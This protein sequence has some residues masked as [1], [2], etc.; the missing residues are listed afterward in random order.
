MWFNNSGCCFFQKTKEDVFKTKIMLLP[1]QLERNIKFGKNS[2]LCA[3]EGYLQNRRNIS[4]VMNEE[5]HDGY[6]AMKR[7]KYI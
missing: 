7:L 5:K 4:Q 2:Q 3:F 6:R 1:L